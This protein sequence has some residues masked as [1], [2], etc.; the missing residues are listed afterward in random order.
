M[1][2]KNNMYI[3]LVCFIVLFTCCECR[4]FQQEKTYNV[5]ITCCECRDLL[6]Y[7]HSKRWFVIYTVPVV[8]MLKKHTCY[9][10][11]Y[12]IVRW[13]EDEYFLFKFPLHTHPLICLQ[14]NEW[15]TKI[16]E[17]EEFLV[18]IDE[19][20]YICF[21]PFSNTVPS[22]SVQTKNTIIIMT[23][24]DY[25]EVI[26]VVSVTI[27]QSKVQIDISYSNPLVTLNSV[28]RMGYWFQSH[29]DLH[30]GST[31]CDEM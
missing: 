3:E 9:N 6:H 30:T 14:I 13:K 8:V 10:S 26:E 31:L 21:G 15:S 7:L 17:S 11:F 24:I 2:N 25:V 18:I 27:H 23:V 28:H 12:F 22:R 1:Q 16:N 29:F 5:L 4:E 19:P 20:Y